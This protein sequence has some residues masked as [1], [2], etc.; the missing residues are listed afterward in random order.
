M[1]GYYDATVLALAPTL[2][3]IVTYLLSRRDRKVVAEKV[4]DVK[5]TVATTASAADEKLDSIHIL[6]NNR[7]T[8]ALERIATLEQKLGLEPGE[9][10]GA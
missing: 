5:E 9:A 10:L 7:M 6:V 4:E 3:I 2:A 1:S 8:E